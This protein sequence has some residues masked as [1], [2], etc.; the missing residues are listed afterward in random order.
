MALILEECIDSEI[1][2]ILYCKDGH[3]CITFQVHMH[4]GDFLRKHIDPFLS[5]FY[6]ASVAFTLQ[7]TPSQGSIILSRHPGWFPVRSTRGT[8]LHALPAVIN[9]GRMVMNLMIF[10]HVSFVGFQEESHRATTG[11]E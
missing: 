2:C 5:L 1:G 7:G 10:L 11:L 3:I 9:G 4:E 8:F 6:L